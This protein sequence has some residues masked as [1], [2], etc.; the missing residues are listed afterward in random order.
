MKAFF[1]SSNKSLEQDP[2]QIIIVELT[3]P[4]ERIE[5]MT[6]RPMPSASM[7]LVYMIVTNKNH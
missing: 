3:I 1:E 6:D 7:Y 4:V 2:G 5:T